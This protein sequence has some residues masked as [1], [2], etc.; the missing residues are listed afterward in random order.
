[1]KTLV[2]LLALI[3]LPALAAPEHADLVLHNGRIYTADAARPWIDA[4]AVAGDRII[5]AGAQADIDAVRGPQT[6]VIDL[7]GAF[8]LPGFND[9]HVHVEATGALLVGVNLLDVHDA[10][11]FTERIREATTRVPKGS[12]ITRGDWGAYEQWV[13]GSAGTPSGRSSPDAS[14]GK[15][16][17]RTRDAARTQPFLPDRSL[18]D[19]VTPDHPVL[20]NRFDRSVYLANSL[21]LTLAGVSEATAS[22]AG[23][24]IA[25]D[26]SGRITGVLRG[27][28]VDLVRKRIPPL[29][30]PERLVHTRAVLRETESLPQRSETY[31][32]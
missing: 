17:A 13:S 10:A 18:I 2:G 8:A 32:S 7:R 23:G 22:P 16:Q 26:G 27:A 9:A 25:R 20:V 31:V 24:E 19:A 29:S 12:W 1:M 11:A 21:A 30:L 15:T 6:R 28:A 5:A 4:V 14:S 3:I